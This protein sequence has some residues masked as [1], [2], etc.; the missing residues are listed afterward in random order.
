MHVDSKHPLDKSKRNGMDEGWAFEHHFL[1]VRIGHSMPFGG[2]LFG[3]A[4]KILFVMT[5]VKISLMPSMS[6]LIISQ[7][8]ILGNNP[9]TRWVP[10]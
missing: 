2:K 6:K 5:V 7:G 8:N 1:C 9:R 3:V 10:G 4:Q